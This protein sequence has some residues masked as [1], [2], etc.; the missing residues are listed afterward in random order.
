[1]KKLLKSIISLSLAAVFTL[2]AYAAAM[3]EAEG[4]IFTSQGGQ[5][6]AEVYENAA[7]KTDVAVRFYKDGAVIKEYTVSEMAFSFMAKK[8][9]NG[10][11]WE[12]TEHR[13]FDES[14]NQLTI[15]SVDNSVR[16][17]DIKTGEIVT[18]SNP[19]KLAMLVVGVALLVVVV[20]IYWKSSYNKTKAMS[21]QLR[22]E[23]AQKQC[24][25][26]NGDG[27]SETK[28]ETPSKPKPRLPDIF[29]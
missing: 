18:Q 28:P 17:F 29:D 3:P 1:M 6:K 13:S 10:I 16:V 27:Q 19:I 20:R 15:A 23:E 14:T 7:E 9:D 12:K 4:E 26:Q 5:T 8:T 25:K 24:E 21:D 11:E 2:T 22:R